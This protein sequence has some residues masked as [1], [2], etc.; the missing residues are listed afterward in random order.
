M[1]INGPNQTNWNPYQKQVHQQ[2]QVQQNPNQDKLE[3]SK[4]A[5]SMQE[6]EKVS[7]PR[8]ERIDELKAQVDNGTYKPDPSVT[9][10]KMVNFFSE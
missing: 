4:E 8:S 6:S 2:K 9:A 3:I 7:T 1:K 10:R 5:K